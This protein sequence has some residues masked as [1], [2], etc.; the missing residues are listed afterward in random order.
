VRGFQPPGWERPWASGPGTGDAGERLAILAATAVGVLGAV[1]WITGALGGW[2]AF[3][4]G[5][6]L[7]AAATATVLTRLPGHLGDPKAAWPPPWSSRLPGAV[8]LYAIAGAVSSLLVIVVVVLCRFAR[9]MELGDTPLT[10]KRPRLVGSARSRSPGAKW[11]TSRDLAD[12][13]V[14]QPGNGRLVLGRVGRRLIATEARHSVLVL[15]PT[16]SGKTTGLAIPALL[17][18]P[19]P[20]VA[21]SVKGDLVA[22]TRT[23]RAGIGEAWVFDPTGTA[24]VGPSS[25]WSP[26][27]EAGSWT[28]A[29]RMASWLVEATPSRGGLSD[30]AF[31]F[32]SAAKLLS[33]LLL[34]AARGGRCMADVVRWVNLQESDEPERLLGDA[35]EID[36]GVALVAS[37]GRDERI[38]SSIYTTLETV[39]APYEDPM[40]ARSADF[41][42]IDPA[43]LLEGSNTLFLCGPA[44]EQFRVQGVFSALVSSV[45]NAAVE[46]VQRVGAL[47]RPLLI[48]LDEAANIA[49]LRDLDTLASTAAGLGI[50]LVTVCQDLAQ[51]ST[52][53]GAERARTIANNHRAKV[54]LSG[55]ADVGTLDT[56]S[57]LAGEQAVRE[58]SVTSDLRDGR[59]STSSSIAYRR[60][61]PA[62]ELR[63]IRPGEGVLVYG[64]L[65]AARLTLRPW[66]RD[67]TLR[68]RAD[69]QPS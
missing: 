48:V 38:R 59:R 67:A 22:L 33:P 62:D 15:G 9:K 32:A 50:Q 40:V 14:R 61:A 60:L 17:E 20:V 57:G 29:Q 42:D 31:W 1:I 69:E 24:G 45:V 68:R 66:Y 23:F 36:A 34:A 27:A 4:H 41:P 56:L 64:Y 16:Q 35:G 44:H 21:T 46:R 52:R 58:E 28:G 8:W 53:Y 7:S 5:P 6:R 3:G 63:R 30:G 18:W 39:L 51:L 55:I 49:P 11:A 37:T 65:P 19:G 25:R 12:L 54:V 13:R 26:L 47:D 43:R 2:L 10:G